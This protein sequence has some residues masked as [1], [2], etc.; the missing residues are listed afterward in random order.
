MEIKVIDM[1]KLIGLYQ[2]NAKL[3]KKATHIKKRI[4]K[5]LIIDDYSKNIKK[6]D[7]KPYFSCKEFCFV[8][9]KGAWL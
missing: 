3:L 4:N 7:D 1:G 9:S 6:G 2:I 8:L 5:P